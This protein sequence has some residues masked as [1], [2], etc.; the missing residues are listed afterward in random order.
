MRVSTA[1]PTRPTTPSVT[2]DPERLRA[3]WTT[4][5]ACFELVVRS[6]SVGLHVKLCTWL[7]AGPALEECF[8]IRTMATFE[9]WIA[10]APTK[11]DHPVA[12]EEV[13]RFAD[14]HLCR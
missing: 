6:H 14:G 11:F 9:Q 10:K 12:H 7:H 4:K 13:K 1:T 8:V 5:H 3:C 2:R